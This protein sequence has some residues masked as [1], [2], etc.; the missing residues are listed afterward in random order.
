MNKLLVGA[1]DFTDILLNSTK[2]PFLLIDDGPIA[3]AFAERFPRAKLFDPSQHSFN[4]LRGIDYKRARDFAQTVY[5]ASPEGKDT[6]TVRN[7]RRALARLLLT[8]TRLDRM[9]SDDEKDGDALAAVED[10]LFSPVVRQVL[11][12][13]TDQFSFKG[14]VIARINRAELGDFDAFVLAQLLIGQ[15]KEQIVVPDFGF[16]GRPL[17]MSLIRQ[18]RLMAGINTFSEVDDKKLRQALELIP[19]KEGAQCTYDDAVVLAQY[20]GLIPGQVNHTEFVQ[21]LTVPPA[22]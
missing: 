2:Q 22:P 9:Q 13:P 20:A 5:T 15:H 11:C 6:L 21:S 7:G 19:D 17:H 1:A 16:Y 3:D 18:N 4:P 14:S 10:L 12:R 8:T